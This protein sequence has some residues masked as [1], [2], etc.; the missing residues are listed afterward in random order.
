MSSDT[1]YEIPGLDMDGCRDLS[2]VPGGLHKTRH[3]LLNRPKALNA[4]NLDMIERMYA[5]LKTWNEDEAVELVIVS[6]N[7]GKAF[8]AGGDVRAIY[9][10]KM[11]GESF[12]LQRQFFYK[13][14]ELD[15]L[16]SRL[17][18][19][20]VAIL[21]GITM[22]GGVGISV[23][24]PYRI[25]TENS[26][27][28]MPE[29]A[30][31]LFPDVGGSFFL[32]RLKRNLG[33]VLG[34]SGY[35]LKGRDL[36]HAGIATHY[37][38]SEKLDDI[39]K[40]RDFSEFKQR[41]AEVEDVDGP[42]DSIFSENEIG[43]LEKY[44]GNDSIEGIMDALR[45]CEGEVSKRVLKSMESASPTSLKVTLEQ[46]KR[47]KSMGLDEC[48]RMEYQMTQNF[49]DK[50]DFFEGVR[51]ILVDKDKSPKW[52]P[53]TLASVSKD[54]VSAYFESNAPPLEFL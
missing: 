37:V 38:A 44:F 22:G 39:V 28:A 14:Y 30:L 3:L 6:G 11:R 32:P 40:S 33:L 47:G 23:H 31:G 27:F 19:P 25:A 29:T 5:Q 51:A 24:A 2:I 53:S 48:L 8:C 54:Q 41:L 12:D 9:D 34:L 45:C 18:K 15:Y 10:E 49:M 20:Y 50:H 35:R 43:V 4:L 21:D 16:I 1:R 36:Y 13:E 46:L 17:S 7:G 52:N 42:F 26:V